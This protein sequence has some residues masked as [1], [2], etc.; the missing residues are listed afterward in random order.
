MTGFAAVSISTT[1]Q[2]LST[3]QAADI[4]DAQKA[5]E[6][7]TVA[8]TDASRANG[9]GQAQ[10]AQDSSESSEPAHIKHE[11]ELIS[12]S[13]FCNWTLSDGLARLEP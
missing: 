5:E 1:A 6:G 11:A 8:Q 2:A 12:H 9:G 10:G 13:D 3:T 4:Q 7:G